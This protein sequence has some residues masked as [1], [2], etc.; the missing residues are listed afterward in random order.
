[1]IERKQQI[2]LESPQTLGSCRL[3]LGD[4]VYLIPDP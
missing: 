3:Y 4:I 1:V 2:S